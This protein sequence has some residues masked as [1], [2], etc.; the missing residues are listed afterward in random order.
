MGWWTLLLCSSLYCIQTL[1]SV[2]ILNGDQ[3][4]LWLGGA[5]EEMEGILL[6]P[7]NPHQV[8]VTSL[9]KTR[10]KKRSGEG[11]YESCSAE[12]R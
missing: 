3:P 9:E 2:N 5:A 6:L 1:H 10:R 12:N 7:D 4:Q 8:E 11:K